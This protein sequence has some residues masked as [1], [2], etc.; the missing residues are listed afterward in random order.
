MGSRAKR[1]D[2]R[3]CA[4]RRHFITK[5]DCRNIGRKLNE[6]IKHHHTDDAVSVDRL[7]KEFQLESPSPIIAYKPQGIATAQYE[8]P[9]DTFFLV[10]MTAFQADLFTEFSGKILC[11]DSTHR[12]NQYKHK[13]VT[14]VV[15]DEFHNGMTLQR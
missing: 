2:F 6:F 14:M 7:V 11:L 10:I 4:T 8:L 5:Q 15:P 12:T 9:D 3:T 1:Q 13:L